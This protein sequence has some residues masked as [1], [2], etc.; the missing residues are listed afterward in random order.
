[1]Q[2]LKGH[3]GIVKEN[4][5]Q[6]YKETIKKQTLGACINK[7]IIWFIPKPGDPKHITNWRKITLLNVY[8]KIL[9]KE[10]AIHIKN[11]LPKI[12]SLKKIGFIRGHFILDNVVTTWESMEWACCL[13][14]NTLFIKIDFV[15]A[16]DRIKYPFILAML[17]SQNRRLWAILPHKD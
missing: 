8:Y 17:K 14:L 11:I 1:M 9:A 10:L 4:L 16:Y 2:I 6:V 5:L 3:V 15:K 7:G 13:G 12:I